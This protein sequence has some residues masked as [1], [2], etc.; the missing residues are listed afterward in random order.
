MCSSCE[1]QLYVQPEVV[2]RGG[3]CAACEQWSIGLHI[4]VEAHCDE[5]A[6]RVVGSERQLEGRVAA[7]GGALHRCYVADYGSL[8]AIRHVEAQVEVVVDACAL[9][10]C[11]AVC[12]VL[13]FVVV[14]LAVLSAFRLTV[15]YSAAEEVEVVY[16]VSGTDYEVL[17]Q[18][19]VD[20][21]TRH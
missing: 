9:V 1:R 15:F 14:V 7:A 13:L 16:L 2:C 19:F 10:R 21:N 20:L 3:I 11:G 6:E 18:S 8:L 17:R 4:I 12:S 5:S